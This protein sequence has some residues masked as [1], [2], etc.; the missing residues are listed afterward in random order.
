MARTATYIH[1]IVQPGARIEIP[2]PPGLSVGDAVDIVLLADEKT[3]PVTSSQSLA[4]TLNSLPEGIGM[5]TS[6]SAADAY[7][8]QERDSWE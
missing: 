2:A 4:D 6:A 1:A 8:R 5:F 3:P 7:L